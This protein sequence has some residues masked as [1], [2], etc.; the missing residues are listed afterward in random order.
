MFAHVGVEYRAS[1]NVT[2]QLQSVKS[3]KCN[4]TEIRKKVNHGPHFFGKL[5]VSFS[6]DSHNFFTFYIQMIVI[7]LSHRRKDRC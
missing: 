4:K 5:C 1:E 7:N 2:P 6:F 3:F